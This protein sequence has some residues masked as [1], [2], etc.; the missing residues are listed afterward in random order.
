TA[1]SGRLTYRVRSWPSPPGM[2]TVV[3]VT[4]ST[5]GIPWANDSNTVPII[6][7][8][9]A[10]KASR[11]SSGESTV[12]GSSADRAS[13]PNGA[14]VLTI[15]GS[16]RGSV[17]S[18]QSGFASRPWGMAQILDPELCGLGR[19]LQSG[20]DDLAH[21]VHRLGGGRRPARVRVADQLIEA[22]RNDLPAETEA[23]F[24]PSAL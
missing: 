14:K 10:V 1:V 7:S 17:P 24:A 16:E 21:A 12:T 5:I 15:L 3:V 6:S 9:S 2:V 4:P 13:M 18:E 23:V 11:S 20:D 19:F 22:V 8:I